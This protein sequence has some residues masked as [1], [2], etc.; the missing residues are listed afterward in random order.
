M[1]ETA[2]E[3]SALV[4]RINEA[5]QLDVKYLVRIIA[6]ALPEIEAL[7]ARGMTH[8]Q[9]YEI[10]QPLI[11]L[12]KPFTLNYYQQLYL[13]ARRKHATEPIYWN[14]PTE[15]HLPASHIPT[16]VSKPARKVQPERV[17]AEPETSIKPSRFVHDEIHKLNAAAEKDYGAAFLKSRRK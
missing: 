14:K 12:D 16:P 8:Q 6:Q 5:K 4:A 15:A 17:E 7:R 9:I 10:V 2:N 11:V 3:V 13:R 1:N